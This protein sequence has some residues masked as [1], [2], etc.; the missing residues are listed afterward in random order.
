MTD[1]GPELPEY[2]VEYEVEIKFRIPPRYAAVMHQR[3]GGFYFGVDGWVRD[4]LTWDV[5]GLWWEAPQ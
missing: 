3:A 1:E 4:S 5:I 2:L